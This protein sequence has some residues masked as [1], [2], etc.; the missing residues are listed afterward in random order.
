MIAHRT[1]AAVIPVMKLTAFASLVLA[2]FVGSARGGA[3]ELIDVRRV[4][5]AAPHNAFTDLIRHRGEWFMTFR[6]GA[7]HVSAAGS[8][9]V[10]SSKDGTNWTS[11]ALLNVAGQDL[12]DSKLSEMPDGRL[13]LLACGANRTNAGPASIHRAMVAIS[14]DG[15]EWPALTPVADE[16]VWLWRMTWLGTKAYGVA[17]DTGKRSPARPAFTSRLWSTGDGLHFT[18]AAKPMLTN[19]VPTEATLAFQADGTALCLQRH[20]GPAPSHALLGKSKP[21]YDQWAWQDLGTFF[22]GPNFIQIPD[23]RWI[24][25]GRIHAATAKGAPKTVLCELDPTSG[26]LIPLLALPSGGDTSY[27]GL[28]WHEGRLWISYYS[29]HEKKT[30]I[31]LARVRL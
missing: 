4:W 25:C 3:P 21:P 26:K 11:A 18:P 31:Y 29:S 9:R 19:G 23:G 10:L 16:N 5:D 6:E 30:A 22:G 2:A 27:P 17:Y 1:Q 15:R 20:D 7:G 12:R 13:H 28:V 24:A 14:K 8:I